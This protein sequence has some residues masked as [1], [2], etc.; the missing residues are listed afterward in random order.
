MT[1]PVRDPVCPGPAP[2]AREKTLLRVHCAVLLRA[3]APPSVGRMPTDLAYDDLGPKTSKSP[4]LLVHGHPFDRSM[5]RPQAEHLA[6]RGHRVV[7]PD[8]RGYGES[9]S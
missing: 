8:L 9:K 4:V 5:W 6:G 1:G 2:S 7:T 3:K